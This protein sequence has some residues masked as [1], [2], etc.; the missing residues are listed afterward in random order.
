LS[1][2][3]DLVHDFPVARVRLHDT[4]CQFMLLVGVHRAA[5][6]N[7]FVAGFYGNIRINQLWLI[8]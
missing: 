8:S 5:E 4:Q 6:V 3:P 7:G 2:N 1:S